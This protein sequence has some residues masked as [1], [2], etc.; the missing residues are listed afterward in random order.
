MTLPLPGIWTGQ[1]TGDITPNIGDP[2]TRLCVAGGLL[3]VTSPF[4]LMGLYELCRG[5]SKDPDSKAVGTMT[6]HFGAPFFVS[7]LV[8]CFTAHPLLLLLT[9]V[10]TWWGSWL[11]FGGTLFSVLTS[12]S[13][14]RAEDPDGKKVY[15]DDVNLEERAKNE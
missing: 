14:V 4:M 10:G 8:L 2:T 13:R 11:Y 7:N 6:L 3:L 15:V 9:F 12:K 1:V 5:K